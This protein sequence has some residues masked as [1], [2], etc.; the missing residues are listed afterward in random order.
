MIGDTQLRFSPWTYLLV[1]FDGDARELSGVHRTSRV[2]GPRHQNLCRLCLKTFFPPKRQTYTWKWRTGQ[3]EQ[4]S[5]TCLSSHKQVGLIFFIQKSYLNPT[6]FIIF[7]FFPQNQ[8]E[9]I[10]LLRIQINVC[11]FTLLNKLRYA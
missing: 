1:N 8:V 10:F 7:N 11:T 9:M 2:F 6:T 4:I 5:S 3:K